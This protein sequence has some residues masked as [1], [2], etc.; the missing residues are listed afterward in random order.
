MV[1]IQSEGAL[2]NGSTV[3]DIFITPSFFKL[4]AWS[5]PCYPP[6]KTPKQVFFLTLSTFC[7]FYHTITLLSIYFFIERQIF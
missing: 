3:V 1:S 5:S 7:H 4:V 6:S 2:R